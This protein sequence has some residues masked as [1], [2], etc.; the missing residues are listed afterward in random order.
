MNRQPVEFFV[1]PS[2]E[3]AKLLPLLGRQV[4][5]DSV[6]IRVKCQMTVLDEKRD[7]TLGLPEIQSSL[8]HDPILR[9]A[10]LKRDA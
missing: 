7:D 3:P 10:F 8:T 5:F 2:D 4:L 9:R 1:D 6:A